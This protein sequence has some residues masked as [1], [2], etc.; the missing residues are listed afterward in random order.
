MYYAIAE[1]GADS[2]PKLEMPDEEGG[3]C[4]DIDA[5]TCPSCYSTVFDPVYC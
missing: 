2:K 1:E 4:D 5:I 3:N